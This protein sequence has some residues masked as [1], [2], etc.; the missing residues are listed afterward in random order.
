MNI[1]E[2]IKDRKKIFKLK[3]KWLQ[4]YF[5]TITEKKFFFKFFMIIFQFFFLLLFE[6]TSG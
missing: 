1:S 3:V 5:T 2:I 6:L 4:K